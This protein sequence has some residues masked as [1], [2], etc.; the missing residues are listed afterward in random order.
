MEWF[1][2]MKTW[3]PSIDTDSLRHWLEG[4]DRELIS[5]KPY[6]LVGVR[7]AQVNRSLAERHWPAERLNESQ[8]G[9]L[10]FDG[11]GSIGLDD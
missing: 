9:F 7:K 6:F 10:L 8:A 4:P 2:R 5:Q 1:V 3:T 11:I